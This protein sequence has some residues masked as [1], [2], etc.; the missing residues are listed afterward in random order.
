MVEISPLPKAPEI[1]LGV[2]DVGGLIVP[3]FDVRQRFRLPARAADPHDQ[4]LLA[5]TALGTAALIV[6]EVFGVVESAPGSITP[7]QEIVPGLEFVSGVYRQS[8]GMI[9]I[10]DLETFL[11]VEETTALDEALAVAPTD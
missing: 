1:V 11:S 8:D 7:P 10:H 2:I 6:D 9:L 5:R 4:I 3:V